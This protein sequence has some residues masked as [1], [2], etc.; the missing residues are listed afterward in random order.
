MRSFASLKA[1]F[2]GGR[3]PWV[4]VGGLE[5]KVKAHLPPPR[6]RVF[7][8]REEE[9]EGENSMDTKTK[10]GFSVGRLLA[11][12][13]ALE[14]LNHQDILKA[15]ARYAAWDWG[16]EDAECLESNEQAIERGSGCLSGLYRDRHGIQFLIWTHAD[17]SATRVM[18]PWHN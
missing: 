10:K 14:T 1:L 11:T 6:E 2:L 18:L 4:S 9:E 5:N 13:R 17:R 7:G 15:L 12:T 16:E 8:K 3:L